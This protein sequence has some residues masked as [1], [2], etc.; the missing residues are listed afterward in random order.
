[1]MQV[2]VSSAR[3][4]GVEPRNLYPATEAISRV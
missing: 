2:M 4:A 3:G 1:M